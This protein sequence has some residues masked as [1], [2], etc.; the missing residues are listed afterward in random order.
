MPSINLDSL[1]SAQQQAVL[2]LDKHLMIIAGPGTGKTKTL[3]NKLVYLLLEQQVTPQKVIALTFTNK[4]AGEIKERLQTL[5]PKQKK[6]PFVGTFHA[7][8]LKFL[9]TK[10]NFKLIDPIARHQLIKQLLSNYSHQTQQKIDYQNFELLLSKF[11]NLSLAE[12][13]LAPKII[14]LIKIYN[15]QLAQQQLIDYDDLLLK[16]LDFLNSTALNYD[17]LLIDEYQDVNA[18]QYQLIKKLLAPTGQLVV[19]GDPKQ[20]IYAF[21]GATPQAFAD[22][23]TDFTDAKTIFLDT[24][25]RSSQPIIDLAA[26]L[27]PKENKLRAIQ[28]LPSNLQLIKTFN[29][30]SEASWL[31]NKIEELTGGTDLIQA[32]QHQT[33]TSTQQ[34]KDIAVIYRTHHLGKAIEEKFYEHGIPYQQVGSDNLFTQA[35]I[36]QLIE[37]LRVMADKVEMIET[38]SVFKTWWLNLNLEQKQALLNLPLTQLCQK[39]LEILDL[40]KKIEQPR[41]QKQFYQLLSFLP[42]FEILTQPLLAFLQFIDNLADNNF[43]DQSVDRVTLL[44]MHAAKGLEFKTVFLCSFEEGNIP[45]IH[46]QDS[47]VNLAEEK[48]LLYVALTRAKQNLYLLYS[49]KRF[50]QTVQLSSFAS[51]LDLTLLEQVIDPSLKTL[52]KRQSE[53]AQMKLF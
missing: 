42:Q 2:A 8:A 34:F 30:F 13:N 1:N 10:Q 33:L 21:R 19:I 7:L 32:T 23:Q 3:I 38:P 15:Q 12:Q 47:Q 44:T 6:L 5:L 50:S 51:E 18:L 29:Q 25:Y 41:E 17:Y 22:F 46:R 40:K 35:L 27:F 26:S 43:Y 48:R 39:L 53:K 52:A 14:N 28:S 11:K 4:A 31:I 24:N 16:F 20:A 9:Q 37:A 49:Q 45:L 36:S